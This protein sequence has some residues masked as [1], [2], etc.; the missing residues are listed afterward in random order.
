MKTIAEQIAELEAEAAKFEAEAKAAELTEEEK[1]ITELRE[2]AQAAREAK[3]ANDT[4]RRANDLAHRVRAAEI[5]A[6]GKYLVGGF[7]LVGAF[8][9]GKS[10]PKDQLPPGGVIVIRDAAPQ[11]GALIADLEH[12]NVPGA[13]GIDQLMIEIACASI[14]DPDP[15]SADGVKLGEF[16]RRYPAAATQVAGEARRLGGAKLREAKRGRE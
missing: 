16:F 3:A 6:A 14:V 1:A 4:K 12:K 15:T 9:L 2:R 5:A 13:K 11:E 7:D 8:P 10:P